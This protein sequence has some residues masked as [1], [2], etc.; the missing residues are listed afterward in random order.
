MV[1]ETRCHRFSC[2]EQ[3]LFDH[4]GEEMT[5][6]KAVNGAMCFMAFGLCVFPL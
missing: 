6:T 3:A 5:A 4:A 2:A 1:A